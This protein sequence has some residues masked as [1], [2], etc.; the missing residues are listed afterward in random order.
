MTTTVTYGAPHHL[1]ADGEVLTHRR[2][3]AGDRSAAGI[4]VRTPGVGLG[5]PGIGRPVRPVESPAGVCAVTPGSGAGVVD[6]LTGIDWRCV[7]RR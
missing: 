2:T 7:L 1:V 5:L 4:A 3:T 6:R